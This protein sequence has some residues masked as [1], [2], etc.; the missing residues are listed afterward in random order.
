[1]VQAGAGRQMVSSYILQCRRMP[2]RLRRR[3]RRGCSTGLARRC[4]RV[5]SRPR[6]GS[7]VQRMDALL[8]AW[9]GGECEGK[10]AWGGQCSRACWWC[11]RLRKCSV[12]AA[13]GLGVWWGCLICLL[14]ASTCQD[15]HERCNFTAMAWSTGNVKPRLMHTAMPRQSC[16]VLRAASNSTDVGNDNNTHR[17]MAVASGAVKAPGC[18]LTVV[19]V[20]TRQLKIQTLCR[21]PK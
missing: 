11:Q 20:H 6:C 16:R 12:N 1:M 19:D 2:A 5:V 13:E 8:S 21:V 18:V 17:T 3:W 14:R 10:A 7:A 15:S 9:L 4:Q